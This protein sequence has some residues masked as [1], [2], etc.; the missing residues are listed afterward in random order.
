MS[1]TSDFLA[2]NKG[3]FSH[4]GEISCRSTNLGGKGVTHMSIIRRSLPALGLAA[5]AF[6]TTACG[7]GMGGDGGFS[8]MDLLGLLLG[9]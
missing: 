3:D 4:Q 2:E 1:Q 8:I 7:S 6:A 5:L 9:S